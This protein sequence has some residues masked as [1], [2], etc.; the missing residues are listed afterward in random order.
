M[1]VVSACQEPASYG[2]L[3]FVAGGLVPIG[4]CFEGFVKPITV[5]N[6]PAVDSL[7]ARH[8]AVLHHFVELRRRD[9]DPRGSSLAG[10]PAPRVICLL[11]ARGHSCC[12]CLLMSVSIM[13]F[14][15]TSWRRA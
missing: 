2:H 12:A 9:A 13:I 1:V 7:R 11:V 3:P 8:P 4:Q 14:L 5:P 15:L 6:D 10:E